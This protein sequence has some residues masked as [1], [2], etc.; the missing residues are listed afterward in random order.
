VIDIFEQRGLAEILDRENLAEDRF[1]ALV[2]PAIALFQLQELVIG[3]ALNLDE[4]RHRGDF[5]DLA[6]ILAKA[7]ASGEAESHSDPFTAKA[8]S[9]WGRLT[10]NGAAS[11]SGARITGGGRVNEICTTPRFF[12][13]W[14]PFLLL[15]L[16]FRAGVFELLFDL[17]GLVFGDIGLHFL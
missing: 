17:G 16:D 1:Q 3:G 9:G 8:V 15:Q 14:V 4:V 6:E 5:L 7:F 2:L 10:S 12:N 11:P 13:P